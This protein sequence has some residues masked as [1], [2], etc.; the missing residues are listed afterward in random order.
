MTWRATRPPTPLLLAMDAAPAVAVQGAPSITSLGEAER[1]DMDVALYL[2][3][4][5]RDPASAHFHAQLAM[6]YLQ[7]GRE[8]ASASDIERAEAEAR[9]S[10]VR[11]TQNN[12]AAFATLVEALMEQHKFVEAGKAA[13]QL[14]AGD[15][16]QP[17]YQSML[18]EVELEL[19]NYNAAARAFALVGSQRKSLAVT[20]RLARLAE[21]RG[22]TSR[23][24][25]LLS[26]AAAEA[27]QDGTMPSEQGAWFQLRVGD[28]ELRH[29]ALE[30][31]E[32][33]ITHG[34]S[35]APADHRLLSAMARL[36]A[37]QH[38]WSST[39]D[40]GNQAIAM[41]LDP[42]MLGLVGDAY[43]AMGDSAKAVEYF[44][45]MEVAVPREAG[46][47]HRA[48]SFYLLDHGLRIADVRANV[49]AELRTRHDI[50]GHD[51]LGWALYKSGRFA[52][53]RVEM[54]RAMA[55]GTQDAT[56]FFSRRHGGT[57]A[58]QFRGCYAAS[59][60]G[61]DRE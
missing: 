47:Y 17:S 60:E 25:A 55:Q 44:K 54:Q 49:T 19:G 46:A 2:S 11:R 57:C 40:F 42:A 36:R 58:G 27:N 53:A 50:Y 35:I 4:V 13:R 52:H 24:H 7:R 56:L 20:T 32:K 41:V 23:A 28:S 5:K 30:A 38:N 12:G 26:R 31:A 3:A 59:G 22:D 29:G 39:I 34:L 14:V 33:A 48:W 15:P 16:T 8:R 1:R 10:L 6:Q 43:A 37:A 51:L 61:A 21:I 9:A 18:G 45:T